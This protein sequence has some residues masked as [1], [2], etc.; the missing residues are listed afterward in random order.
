M[1]KKKTVMKMVMMKMVMMKM[2]MRKMVMMMTKNLTELKVMK[3]V[4]H[5]TMV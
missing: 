3:I 1:M 5:P 2:V 4:H